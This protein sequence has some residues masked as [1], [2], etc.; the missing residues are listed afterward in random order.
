MAAGTKF[1]LVVEGERCC[2]AVKV[3]GNRVAK[4]GVQYVDVVVV[5]VCVEKYMIK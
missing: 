3:D 4:L 5:P 2:K 1:K